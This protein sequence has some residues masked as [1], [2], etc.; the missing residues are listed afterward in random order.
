MA[1]SLDV[2]SQK[3]RSKDRKGK[4]NWKHLEVQSIDMSLYVC[5]FL[6]IYSIMELQNPQLYNLMLSIIKLCGTVVCIIQQ[7]G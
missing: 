4:L 6:V 7:L 1:L 5:V 3:S 2:L